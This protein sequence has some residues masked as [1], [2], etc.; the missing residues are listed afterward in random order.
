MLIPRRPLAVQSRTPSIRGAFERGYGVGARGGTRGGARLRV[1]RKAPR[2]DAAPSRRGHRAR[3]RAVRRRAGRRRAASALRPH[4]R[5]RRGRGCRVAASMRAL[6]GGAVRLARGAAAAWREGY[7]KCAALV[8]CAPGVPRP[9]CASRPVLWRRGGARAPETAYVPTASAGNAVYEE[10]RR[11]PRA[12]APLGRGRGGQ[13]E[14]RARRSGGGGV[15]RRSTR[16]DDFRRVRRRADSESGRARDRAE[17]TLVLT[18]RKP[19]S[20][21]R[22]WSRGSRSTATRCATTSLGRTASA[23]FRRRGVDHACAP[24]CAQSFRGKTL[25]VRCLRD[26]RAEEE[27]T[28]AYVELAVTRAERRAQLMKQYLFD[29]DDED[30]G[31]RRRRK[32]FRLAF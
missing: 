22:S 26:V 11:R 30:G 8:A 18:P 28:I 12:G 7:R 29:I 32:M 24:N 14:V 31:R 13:G 19:R 5:D 6:E 2:G 4:V 21:S 27:L 25:T 15:P 20:R 16:G 10:G 1:S 3:G 9:P 17:E 23:S